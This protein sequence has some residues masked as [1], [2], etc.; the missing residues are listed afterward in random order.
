MRFAPTAMLLGVLWFMG[1]R[2]QSGLGVGG[3]G[4]R[5]GRGIFNMGKAHI[6]KLDKN[7]KDKVS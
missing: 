3:P 1:R 6:T 2:M 5:G 7:A 4:G